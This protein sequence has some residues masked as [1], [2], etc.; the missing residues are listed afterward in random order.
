MQS[1]RLNY[2]QGFVCKLKLT[3]LHK[4]FC[5]EGFHEGNS[6]MPKSFHD[7]TLIGLPQMRNETYLCHFRSIATH[8]T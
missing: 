7:K 4:L 1:I 2:F 6:G 5:M 8:F 3:M